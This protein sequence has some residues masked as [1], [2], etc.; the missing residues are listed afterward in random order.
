MHTYGRQPIPTPLARSAYRRWSRPLA[1]GLAALGVLAGCESPTAPSL[2]SGAA[3]TAS[4]ALRLAP[5]PVLV[6]DFFGAHG[7]TL[8]AS[9]VGRGVP[10]V[11]PVRWRV[12]DTTVALVDSLGRVE[13]RRVGQTTVWAEQLVGGRLLADSAPLVVAP[14][15]DTAVVIIAHRGFALVSPEN[16]LPAIARAIDLGADAVEIDVML[17]RDGVPV[18][19]HDHDVDRTTNGRGLVA[20]MLAADVRQLDACSWFGRGWAPCQV[21]TLDEALALAAARGGRLL[22]DLKGRFTH[23]QLAA[24]VRQVNAA[25]MHER[26]MIIDFSYDHLLS[27]RA[28]DPTTP[29]GFLADTRVAAERLTALGGASALYAKWLLPDASARAH[30]ASLRDRGVPLGAWTIV[31][32]ADGEAMVARGAR[33]I[34]TDAPLD[35]VA[36]NAAR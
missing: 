11:S 36:L 4:A 27:V 1:M 29:V 14:P 3:S 32:Q 6:T 35:R 26:A 19:M 31:S 34:I 23:E 25:G 13:A 20:T 10:G 21:P 15:A 33:R 8:A 18:V 24:L 16:T 7:A 22:L 30:V 17:T 12:A 9:V 28:T 2:E 5:P